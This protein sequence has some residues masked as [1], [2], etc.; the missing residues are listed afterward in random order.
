MNNFEDIVNGLAM[1]Q[2]EACCHLQCIKSSI[3]M[4][5]RKEMP[6]QYG[7]ENGFRGFTAASLQLDLSVFLFEALSFY[8]EIVPNEV[9]ELSGSS[10]FSNLRI[11]RNN[12]HQYYKSGGYSKK[13]ID[14]I[15]TKLRQ[16]K[17]EKRDFL[18]PLRNDVSLVY[19]ITNNQRKLIGSDQFIFHCIYEADNK[20]W[21]GDDYKEYATNL[22]TVIKEIA[23]SVDDSIYH[24][25]DFSIVSQ[26]PQIELFDYKSADMFSRIQTTIP[27]AFRLMLTL[28]HISYGIIQMSQLFE[29]VQQSEL[30]ECF[31]TKQLSIK[32]DEAFDNIQSILTH[33]EDKDR[34]LI[35]TALAENEIGMD[36]LNARTFAQRLRNTIHYQRIGINPLLCQDGTTPSWIKAI[37]LSSA[38]VSNMDELGK[39]RAT[40]F[41][42][43]CRLQ[44]AIQ[45]CFGLNK[46]LS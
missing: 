35:T 29:P 26:L 43:L 10:F 12:I 3:E 32:Y 7:K 17:M 22:S 9:D 11:V 1:L 40:I 46:S 42:E 5:A 19:Q 44:R 8:R 24:L 37:Y 25:P 13:A 4:W 6:P 14:I 45:S 39:Q 21:C 18:Y 15:N 23:T 30:W 33:S 36:T 16:Y 31:M 41:E 2:F 34:H 28:Y 38:G 27:T 20:T